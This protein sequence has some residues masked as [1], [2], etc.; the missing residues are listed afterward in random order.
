MDRDREETLKGQTGRNGQGH[1]GDTQKDRRAEMDRDIEETGWT[2]GEL[3]DCLDG[4]MG[5]WMDGWMDGWMCGWMGG[6]MGGQRDIETYRQRDRA[7]ESVTLFIWLWEPNIHIRSNKT[8][9]SIES[10]E[11]E[12]FFE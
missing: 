2:D 5:G 8:S 12:V 6:W 11:A 9:L 4:W 3:A 10:M 1:R 7:Q